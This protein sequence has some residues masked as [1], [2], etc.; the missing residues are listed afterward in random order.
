MTARA[1]WKADLALGEIKVP[2]KLYAAVQDT[3]IHFRLLHAADHAPVKQQMVDP[4]TEQPVP[5]EALKKA[6]AIDRGVYVLL[7]EEEQA[8]LTPKPSRLISVEQVVATS[9]VDER[10]FDRPY[11]LGPDGDD[12]GYFALAEALKKRDAVGIAHWVLR[13]KRYVGALHASGGYL[14]VDTLRYAQEV[15]EVGAV[16]PNA[17]RAPDKR[18]IALAEQLIGAL[19]DR[20]DPNEFRDEYQAQLKALL[21]AKAAGKVVRF[22]KAPKRERSDSLIASL[23]ASIK[24]QNKEASHGR[25]A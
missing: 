17:N 6:V 23:Q 22:P 13:N 9:A 11:Y 1:M 25:R 24:A 19:E 2:V 21:A 20:F 7:T 5:A 16:R 8:A 18:E 3:K 10:W 15:V 4:A 14:L 12:E